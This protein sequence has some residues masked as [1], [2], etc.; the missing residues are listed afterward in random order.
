MRDSILKCVIN[1]WSLFINLKIFW[2]LTLLTT[3][4]ARY[5]LLKIVVNS[6]ERLVID[7]DYEINVKIVII[8]NVDSLITIKNIMRFFIML[9][10]WLNMKKKIFFAIKSR[11]LIYDFFFIK[12]DIRNVDDEIFSFKI[13]FSFIIFLLIFNNNKMMAIKSSISY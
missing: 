8:I 9:I 12:F 11:E 4:R 5:D 6:I 10:F 2:K 13:M 3:L 1:T 7:N